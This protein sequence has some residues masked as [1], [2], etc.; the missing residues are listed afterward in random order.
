[1]TNVAETNDKSRVYVTRKPAVLV[2]SSSGGGAN[3][4]YPTQGRASTVIRRA[5]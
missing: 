5:G 4:P 1:M 3:G 2:V